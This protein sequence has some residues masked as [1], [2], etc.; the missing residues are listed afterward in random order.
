MAPI[1]TTSRVIPTRKP[2]TRGPLTRLRKGAGQVVKDGGQWVKKA[3]TVLREDGSRLA[4][5]AGKALKKG[6]Q[7]VLACAGT[8]S[9]LIDR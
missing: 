3:G 7:V 4:R 2:V 5:G 8:A 1:A 6:K 9:D